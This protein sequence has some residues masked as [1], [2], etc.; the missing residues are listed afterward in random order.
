MRTHPLPGRGVRPGAPAGA[1]R[2]GAPSWLVAALFL[3]PLAA[4]AAC[5]APS[6]GD[7]AGDAADA[8]PAEAVATT[9]PESAADVSGAPAESAASGPTA[10]PAATSVPVLPTPTEV[11]L[12]AERAEVEALVA[13]LFSGAIGQQEPAWRD[14]TLRSMRMDDF[15]ALRGMPAPPQDAYRGRSLA[16]AWV[17]AFRTEHPIGLDSFLPDNL[18]ELQEHEAQ[19]GVLTDADGRTGVYYVVEVLGRDAAGTPM[20]SVLSRGL[21]PADGAWSVED[22]AAQPE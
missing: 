11:D 10:A 14:V 21:I 16:E 8:G 6:A 2:R 19:G 18:A 22:V 15:R 17:V 7:T 12:E 4:L 13:D 9:A 1:R 3:L 20:V 5:S